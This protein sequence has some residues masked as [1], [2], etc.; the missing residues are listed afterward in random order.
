MFTSKQLKR[1]LS[2]TSGRHVQEERTLDGDY[3]RFDFSH[4][5]E[6]WSRRKESHLPQ[7]QQQELFDHPLLGRYLKQISTGKTY[8]VEKAYK[9]W[10]GGWYV[11]L[12]IQ[13]NG[14]HAVL[15]WDNINCFCDI[16][17]KDINDNKIKY[18]QTNQQLPLNASMVAHPFLRMYTECTPISRA[19]RACTE[20]FRKLLDFDLSS[21]SLSV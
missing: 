4:N 16:I 15:A 20:I 8:L 11:K 1:I 18:T 5:H 13:N 12:L 2:R 7:I 19:S 21:A 17:V 6:V 3:F 9:E 10:Y 14:S